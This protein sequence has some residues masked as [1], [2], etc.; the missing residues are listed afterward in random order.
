MKY[1]LLALDLDYTLLN[2]EFKISKRNAV[3]IR[4]IMEKGM[5]VTIATGRM[6]RSTLPF[7]RE[8]ALAL[9]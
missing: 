6:V 4:K 7:A 9:P 1:R 2:D 5:K 3:A 8:L